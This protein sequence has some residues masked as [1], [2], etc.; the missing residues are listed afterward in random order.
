MLTHS[1]AYRRQYSD[2][3]A[4]TRAKIEGIE[5]AVSAIAEANLSPDIERDILLRITAKTGH[6]LDESQ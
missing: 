3:A 6:S 1:P 5:A 4:A 2:N